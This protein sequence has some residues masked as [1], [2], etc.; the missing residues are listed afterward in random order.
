M[1]SRCICTSYLNSLQVQIVALVNLLLRHPSSC[2]LSWLPIQPIW[3]WRIIFWEWNRGC[4][5]TEKK[6]G[7]YL[8]VCYL[9]WLRCCYILFPSTCAG[10]KL[11]TDNDY[12]L[13]A[14]ALSASDRLCVC[15]LSLP[16]SQHHQSCGVLAGM[17]VCR[18]FIYCRFCL[19]A[20]DTITWLVCFPEM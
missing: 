1:M 7:L 2:I 11:N 18:D 4:T 16:S 19:G 10:W 14:D 9:P 15:R 8:S 5:I 13:S 3:D 20:G 6:R 17:W 12:L